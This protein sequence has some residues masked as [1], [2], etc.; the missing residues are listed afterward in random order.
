MNV[1][2]HRY[3]I[4]WSSSFSRSHTGEGVLLSVQHLGVW[5]Y[6]NLHPWTSLGDQPLDQQL[7]QWQSG[8]PSEAIQLAVSAAQKDAE[9]RAKGSVGVRYLSSSQNHFLF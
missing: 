1:R 3:Q 2:L 5:G 8:T 9:A 4:P 6:A 7:D